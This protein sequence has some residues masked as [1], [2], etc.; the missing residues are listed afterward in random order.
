[1]SALCIGDNF[2]RSLSYALWS[3]LIPVGYNRDPATPMGYAKIP[4][5][6]SLS[7]EDIQPAATDKE[8]E[9]S[10]NRSK[11]FLTSHVLCSMLILGPC[12][13]TIIVM[14]QMNPEYFEFNSGA[15]LNLNFLNTVFLPLLGLSLGFSILFVRPYHRCECSGNEMHKGNV[16]V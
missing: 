4:L 5:F 9:L 3:I 7:N 13:L 16:I 2:G 14:V 6:Y 15:S 12:L 10:A 8:I 1:M 11:Y